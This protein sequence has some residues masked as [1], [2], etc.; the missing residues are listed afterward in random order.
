MCKIL[1][2]KRPFIWLR[3]FR[4]RCG[5]GVHSPS[6]FDFIT[7]VIYEKTYYYAYNEIEK[8][9]KYKQQIKKNKKHTSRKVNRLLFRMVN[10]FQ[11]TDI[12]EV[13][14]ASSITSLYLKAAK[15]NADY[16]CYSADVPITHF[17]HNLGFLLIHYGENVEKIRE[18][19]K[20]SFNC[21]THQSVLVIEGIYYNS[22]MKQLW[23]EVVADKRAVIT[24]DLYDLGIVFF[25]QK[26]IKQHYKVNF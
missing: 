10:R 12:A 22:S 8:S 2:F 13:G 19:I 1:T 17:T 9:D 3:R 20:E 26:K 24:Y 4:K 6:A 21:V 23:N 25:D 18:I 7:N 16:V 15:Q 11:P 5:Y 14:P